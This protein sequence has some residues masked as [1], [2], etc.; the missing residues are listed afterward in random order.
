MYKKI[1]LNCFFALLIFVKPALAQKNTEIILDGKCDEW[2]EIAGVSQTPKNDIQNWFTGL[3]AWNDDRYLYIQIS[4]S[5]PL[6]IKE[7]NNIFLEID[8]DNNPKTG[9]RVN[10]LG[11]EFGYVFGQR[12][13]FLNLTSTSQMFGHSEIGL[14]INPNY[15]AS[16]FEIAIDLYTHFE[17][18]QKIFH[19]DTIAITL[20]NRRL[21]EDLIPHGGIP[22][23]YVLQKDN[24]YH[25]SK[26]TLNTLNKESLRVMTW[27]VFYDGITDTNRKMQFHSVL[28]G[29]QPD[30]IALN[31]C[32][33]S[34]TADITLALNE[35]FPD[36][37]RLWRSTNNVLGNV[38]CAP[39]PITVSGQIGTDH[40]LQ[41]ALIQTRDKAVK[42]L[43]VINAHLSCCS[44][45]SM[46]DIECLEILSFIDKLKRK[47]IDLGM[48][49]NPAFVILGDMNFVGKVNQLLW[50][51]HN[52][53]SF[54][55]KEG[56]NGPDWNG[57]SLIDLCPLQIGNNF[58][59]TWQDLLKSFSPSRLDYFFYTASVIQPI[60]SFVLNTFL[61]HPDTLKYYNLK[62]TDTRKASDH[63]PV[64]ADFMPVNI[65]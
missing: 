12:H 19:H 42:D 40:R 33:S 9:Y 37:S 44:A 31:E 14:I 55:Q 26:A 8:A 56:G 51:Q 38:I 2:K 6:L 17:S 52:T 7:E 27:N 11:A 3:K 60:N 29:I 32:W 62:K 35:F 65:K 63:F 4:F 54:T 10:G 22:F 45:D 59:Y 64:V 53:S 47:E 57:A 13:G 28:T 24:P 43:L 1:I 50:L 58:T 30:I 36:S 41:Y 15:E 46:R 61:M 18:P 39:Y 23:Q 25:Q 48:N 34:D 20:W 5:K 49:N 16:D 21:N